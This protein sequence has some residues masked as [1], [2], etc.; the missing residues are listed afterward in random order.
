M[1][2]GDEHGSDDDDVNTMSTTTKTTTMK[3]TTMRNNVLCGCVRVAT[4]LEVCGLCYGGGVQNSGTWRN[5][6]NSYYKDVRVHQKSEVVLSLGDL[7]G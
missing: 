2:R 1:E 7:G 3:K 4:P 6:L 5:V